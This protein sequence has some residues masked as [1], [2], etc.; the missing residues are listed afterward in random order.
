MVPERRIRNKRRE[1]NE[2]ENSF[3]GDSGRVDGVE[4][5]ET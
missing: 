5:F 1:K 3:I 2:F 4:G